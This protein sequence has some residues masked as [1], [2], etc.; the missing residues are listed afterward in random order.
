MPEFR[1]NNY[2]PNAEYKL[3]Y[4]GKEPKA[5]ILTNTLEAPLQEIRVFNEDNPSPDGWRNMLIF[6]DNLMALKTLYEDLKEGGPNKFGLRNKIKLI[7][8]DP[9]FATKQDF[10]KD[11]EKAYA[12]KVKGAQFIEFL[13]KR[14][15]FL[16]EILADDGSVFVHLDYKKGHYIKGILDEVFGEVNFIN[17]VIW[18][19]FGFKRKTAKNFPRKHDT[20]FGYGKS[21]E[22]RIWNNIFKSHSEKYL[23]RWKEDDNGRFYR[24]DVNPTGGGKRIIYLDEIEGDLLDSVWSDIPPVNPVAKE[25]FNYPTQKPESLIERFIK[26]TSHEG[27]IILDCFSGSGTTLAVAEKLKRK[28]IGIDCGKLSIYTTQKRILELFT[29]IG[30]GIKDEKKQI[31]RI[32][33]K[34]L[35]DTTRGFFFI[36]EKARKGELDLTDDFLIR[37]HDFLK[38]IPKLDSFSLVCPEKKFFLSGYE[39][40]ENGLKTIQKDHINYKISFIE[41]KAKEPKSEPLKAKSF[42]LYNAGVYDKEV[43]LS[44]NWKAYREFVMKLF[45]VRPHSHD[46]Q[47]FQMDGFIGVYST[48][49]WN[50][51]EKKNVA[52]DH[53]YVNQLHKYLAGKAGDRLYVIV[54][55]DSINF[56]E[57]EIRHG[58]TV[59]TFLK[60][61]ASVLIRLNEATRSGKT[62]LF[63]SFKQPKSEDDVNEVID[64]FGFDFISQPVL[65]YELISGQQAYGMFN[66]DKFIIRLKD[67]RSNGLLYSPDEFENFETLSL[68][69]VDYNYNGETFS[70]D[71]Y[72]WSGDLVKEDAEFVDVIIDPV[73]WTKEKLAV[74]F[75]DIYGNEKFLIFT[76]TDFSHAG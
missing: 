52:L 54:P 45:E 41:P 66:E 19:Y 44:Y 73:K 46:I 3:V 69:M 43:I 72:L 64:S 5:S 22:K 39:E 13:R 27:D 57:D 25:R 71:E 58:E 38:D 23:S 24:D 28:W 42:V 14:L 55:K 65:D 7:Y 2:K 37:L 56:M 21:N 59:Y 34:E 32:A 74:I 75:I 6:G 48:F 49:V 9:P 47:G 61:P 11:K 53:E 17:E 50:Y 40:D 8:I 30:S 51:P 12:D 18:H 36:S 70:L 15:I 16:K 31:E 26:S 76:K 35:I 1:N 29:V 10:M 33:N 20:I 60:V 4:T 67:F 68:V 63:A 62:D